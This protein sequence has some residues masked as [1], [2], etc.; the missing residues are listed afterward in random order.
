MIG[1]ERAAKQFLGVAFE[2]SENLRGE[3]VV[4]LTQRRDPGLEREW[5]PV[6]Q[7]SREVYEFFSRALA[8]FGLLTS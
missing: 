6:A 3:F 2:F 7:M 1:R 4:L 5:G 8:D